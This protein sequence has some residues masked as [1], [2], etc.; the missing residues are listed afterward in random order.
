MTGAARMLALCYGNPGRLDDGLGPAFGAALE[1]ENLAGVT[2]DVDYQLTVEDAMTAA[3]HDVVLFV[4]A[5]IT[6]AEPFFLHQVTPR[7]SLG[8]SSHGAEPEQ[9]L[10]LAA[11]LTG[12]APQGYA[13]GIRGYEF[14]EFG[15]LLSTGA[16]EN[17]AAAL[18]F[19]VPMILCHDLRHSLRVAAMVPGCRPG[20][21][22][23]QAAEG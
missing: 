4:D 9:I 16:V 18:Q 13:L 1:R 20:R 12:S 2:V 15:E 6:G 21:Q 3:A 8:F 22:T 14:D 19:M 5:A 23:A 10:A 17:L 7:A 11:E